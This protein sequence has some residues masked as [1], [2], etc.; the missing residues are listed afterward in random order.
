MA[1]RQPSCRGS[2]SAEPPGS[3]RGPD[4]LLTTQRN[5]KQYE[6]YRSKEAVDAHRA[7]AHFAVWTTFKESGGVVDGSVSK[8]TLDAAP[9]PWAFHG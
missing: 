9:T 2:S 7:T 1:S 8:M 4:D 5:P 3:P 6:V